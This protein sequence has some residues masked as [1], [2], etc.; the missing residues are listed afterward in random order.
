MVIKN[1][2]GVKS[3]EMTKVTHTNSQFHCNR[4]LSKLLTC[5]ITEKSA[6]EAS[7]L[8][9]IG[10]YTCVKSSKLADA[11]ILASIGM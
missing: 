2:R 7:R 6:K 4:N 3:K 10:S 8:K 11:R 5:I 1:L 9:D